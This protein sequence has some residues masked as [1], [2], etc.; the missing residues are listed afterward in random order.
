[1]KGKNNPQVTAT[2]RNVQRMGQQAVQRKRELKARATKAEKLFMGLLK[3]LRINHQFQKLVFTAHRYFVLDFVL[4]SKPR[5]IIEID[6]SSHENTKAYDDER[7]QLI[8]STSRYWK[9]TVIRIT[10][11]QVYN[12]EAIEILRSYYARQFRRHGEPILVESEVKSVKKSPKK[13]SSGLASTL[14]HYSIPGGKSLSEPEGILD[15]FM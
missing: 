5:L 12:G 2:V 13:P 14:T 8:N 15:Y 10:N 6:G 4:N 3:Q 11:E 7:T 1:M 9:Y